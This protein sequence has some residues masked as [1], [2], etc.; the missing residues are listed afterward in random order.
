MTSNTQAWP[1]PFSLD[2]SV[3][4][5]TYLVTGVALTLLKYL[6]ELLA[7]S[8]AGGPFYTPLD[9]L[10][11]LLSTRQEF[12]DAVGPWFGVAWVVWTIPFV[13]IAV[14]MTLRRARDAG[15][16]P[17]LCLLILVPV[18][19]LVVMLALAAAP[20]S[21]APQAAQP[22]ADEAALEAAR[23]AR[24]AWSSPQVDCAPDGRG[25]T[26]PLVA[27]LFGLLVG[28]AYTIG[29][30]ALSILV[31]GSYGAAL[32]FGAPV[33]TGA[34]GGYLFNRPS[35]RT[36]YDT[37]QHA[38]TLAFCCCSAFLLLGLEG[39]LC[40]V[41]AV[42]IF[43]PMTLVGAAIG[44]AI[45]SGA[46]SRQARED[47][48][49][50]G[51][52]LLLPVVAGIEPVFSQPADLMVES[53]VVIAAPADDV[54]RC[55]V[56]FPEIDAEPQW[57]FRWGI[58][59]PLRARIDGEGVGAVRHCEFTTGA[60]VEPITVWDRPHRLAF[61]VTDQPEP[62]FELTPYRDLHPPHLKGSFS[63]TRG[64][65]EL[66]P[67]ADG[68]TRLVGRTW[69]TLDIAPHV[70][71]RVWTDQIVHQIHLRVLDH[72]KATVERGEVEV[73]EIAMPQ[74]VG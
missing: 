4:R 40:V 38:I 65:F 51:C 54:W 45:A 49:L 28:V 30:A 32:F 37:M 46:E 10:S 20:A 42:P 5:R 19:N 29:V 8:A 7:I 56:A 68:G 44:R 71:W 47:R 73:T 74:S 23:L 57:F 66:I 67:L 15:W 69:Y 61:D 16:T 62:L 43:G 26:S 31:L 2:G 25:Q 9:F 59:A 17:W 35:R 53:S 1:R 55:V 6:V 41:M 63:S 64:E 60:F 33:V 13:W 21:D 48:G 18:V 24:E 36:M 52:L 14:A 22:P 34:A 70:Y 50:M 3:D 12:S 27:T 72:I 58:A 11:P 39:L